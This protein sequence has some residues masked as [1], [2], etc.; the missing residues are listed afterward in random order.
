MYLYDLIAKTD[1]SIFPVIAGHQ[2][3]P[4]RELGRMLAAGSIQAMLVGEA[5]RYKIDNVAHYY[6]QSEDAGPGSWLLSDPRYFPSLAPPHPLTWLEYEMT[7]RIR[8]E[9]GW[10]YH[11]PYVGVYIGALVSAIERAPDKEHFFSEVNDDIKW[12][13]QGFLFSYSSRRR[14]WLFNCEFRQAVHSDGSPPE[15][16][17]MPYSLVRTHP[18][19][20]PELADAAQQHVKPFLLSFSFLAA[21]NTIIVD[22]DP[23]PKKARKPALEGSDKKKRR[24]GTSYRTLE[25]RPLADVLRVR[26]RPSATGPGLKKIAITRG[27]FRTYSEAGNGL[28]GRGIYGTFWVPSHVRGRGN[29]SDRDRE[30]KL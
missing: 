30:I 2:T 4:R 7:P 20:R 18:P 12:F 13:L 23:R 22:H 8:L 25:I 6:W 19:D 3:G 10:S 16:N 5:V 11:S 24:S 28:F 9:S 17:D 1:L 21:K 27:H 26:G 29:Q 15:S 14:E